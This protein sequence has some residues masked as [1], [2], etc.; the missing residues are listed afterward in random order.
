MGWV[1]KERGKFGGETFEVKTPDQD[2]R[3][4]LDRIETRLD[5][6]ENLVT[7]HVNRLNAVDESLNKTINAAKTTMRE[8]AISINTARAF[9]KKLP[10]KLP[11][12]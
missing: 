3:E 8:L 11:K 9:L 12:K 1:K 2:L 10:K 4:Q 6:L 7:A 5:E